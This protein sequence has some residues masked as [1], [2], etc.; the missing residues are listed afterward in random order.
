MVPGSVT[1]FAPPNASSGVVDYKAWNL[2]IPVEGVAASQ[3]RD[4]FNDPRSEGRVHRALDIMSNA[5]TPVLATTDGVVRKLHTS[6]RGGITLYQLDSSGSYIY[7]YAHLERYADNVHEGKAVKRGEVIAYVGDTG[8]AGPGNY[9][10][11]FGIST[12]PAPGKWSGGE[13]I[14]PYPLLGGR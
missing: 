6:Q 13:P 5:G 9:H 8:N 11:H 3:L 2:L 14:N 12:V 4:S 1:G 7:C 10:L